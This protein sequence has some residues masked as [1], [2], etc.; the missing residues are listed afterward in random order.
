MQSSKLYTWIDIQDTIDSFFKEEE[1][2][3]QLQNLTFRAYWDGLNISFSKPKSK[4]EIEGI[5]ESIFL[6][7][8]VKLDAEKCN[9]LL[10]GNRGFPVLF[11]EVIP[12]E[13]E[14]IPFQPTLS[15]APIVA[16]KETTNFSNRNANDKPVFFAF[17][18]FKG[19]VGRTLHAI[20][21]ALNL[22]EKHKVLLIDA[23]FEAP[24]ISWLTNKSISFSDFL[25]M[26]HG[27]SGVEDNYESIIKLTADSLRDDSTEDENLFVFPA[28][29]SLK[30]TSPILEI[31]PEHIIKFNSNP[32]FLTD[33]L[34]KL[35][36]ELAVDFIILD[37][38]AG[39]SELSTSWFLDPRINKVFV[40]TLSSQSVLGTAMLFRLL[41]KFEKQNNLKNQESPLP[42]IIISQIPKSSIKEIEYNW[43]DTYSQETTLSTLRGAYAES[44]L[45]LS[46]YNQ[47]EGFSDLT[48]EQIVGRLLGPITLF[49]QEYDT[50]KSLPDNWE[51]VVKLIKQNELDK[52]LIKLAENYPVSEE[53]TSVLQE[54]PALRE[55][56]KE[57]ANKLIF[58]ETE[59]Q[60]DFLITQPIRNLASGFKTTLP[61]AVVVGAKG[62]GKTFLFNQISHLEN[63]QEFGEKVLGSYSNT[64]IVLPIS[65]PA[66]A[67]PVDIRSF[68]KIPQELLAL[69]PQS[70]IEALQINS[71]WLEYIKP[72]ID[73]SIKED[74]TNSQWREKWLDYIAWAGGFR[75]NE[76]GVGRGF[77]ELLR[78]EKVKVIAVF[79][80]LEDL[81]KQFN[82]NAK[83][84]AALESL[85]QD[86]PNWL[87]SLSERYLG[88]LVFVRKDIVSVAISQNSKQFLKKYENYE[89]RW[90]VEEAL[91]LLH[92]ILNKFTMGEHP[93]FSDWKDSLGQKSE[94]ELVQNLHILWGIR[95]AKNTSKEAYSHNWVLGSLANLKKEIQSRDI[96]R[97][98]NS[99]ANKT[100]STTDAKIVTLYNDRILFPAAIRDSIDEV[101][102]NK[103]DEIKIE[104]QPLK[105]VL[106]LLEDQTKNIKFP[107]KP[108]DIK[109]I[110]HE[111][112]VRIL[113]DNGV[114][115]LHNGEYYM[116]ELYRRGMGFDYSRK[117]RP[118]V[119]YF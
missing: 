91:R 52:K 90:N 42:S 69:K 119:L 24:G 72:D 65:L 68:A 56:L 83:Q 104:N 4:D 89:L 43:G 64:A 29:R 46:E 32:F 28:F 5:L 111:S 39:I 102:R 54:L 63:W 70:N 55:R 11:E 31:K 26:L 49:S 2:S 59:K 106:E 80:G 60:D 58:A 35:A 77:L 16:S 100:L 71:I 3:L 61:I 7:R 107:C 23:D 18:S 114:I 98:L 115:V 6:S 86:V 34:V 67:A 73:L 13:L 110:V 15:R 75:I 103:I 95:M 21:L 47:M 85:L 51:E 36:T 20:S 78:N 109:Q 25:A 82:N 108:E 53:E 88:I 81:F 27:D 116:A 19:G 22:S 113:E 118:K 94:N 12:D 87:E 101:G 38:R 93:T 41:S 1:N 33:I 99:A 112:G 48:D 44:F 37:L 96:V 30:S 40:T 9:I 62:S 66:N 79:D 50:L 74:L 92:W 117:G 14:L 84:Q 17:H 8:F 45:N 57:A 97:F 76:N 10:E 105:E